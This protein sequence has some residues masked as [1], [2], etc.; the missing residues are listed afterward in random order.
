MLTIVRYTLTHTQSYTH[1]HTLVW[2]NRKIVGQQFSFNAVFYSVSFNRDCLRVVGFF[3]V[4]WGELLKEGSASDRVVGGGWET[5]GLLTMVTVCPF[6]T[7]TVLYIPFWRYSWAHAIFH[8]VK[9]VTNF[10]SFT[11]LC[12]SHAHTH[13]YTHSYTRTLLHTYKFSAF[14]FLVMLLKQ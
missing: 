12:L 9:Y 4:K 6:P 5:Y 2:L 8:A 3:L 1:T 14:S 11:S 7:P 13:T 10:A